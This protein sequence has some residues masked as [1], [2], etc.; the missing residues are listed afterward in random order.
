[1]AIQPSFYLY[2]TLCLSNLCLHTQE[3][4]VDV[5]GSEIVG[6]VPLKVILMAA[7]YYMKE[8]E[9]H[10]TKIGQKIQLVVNKLGLNS[11]E[12]FKPEEKIIE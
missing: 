6:L 1:M 3:L 5:L 12:E 11:S 10:T 7:H 4:N 8:E 9:Y 2:C